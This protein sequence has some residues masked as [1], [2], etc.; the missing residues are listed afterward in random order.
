MT[1]SWPPD[2]LLTLEEWEALPQGRYRCELAEGVLFVVPNP[3]S[4]H[5][6]A[7]M[8]LGYRIDEQLPPQ[9]TAITEL[10]V[11]V[12][13][14]PLTIRVPDVL[15]TRTELYETN[16]RRVPAA[17]VLLAVETLSDGTRRVD[18]I[19]KLAEYA[20][21][22]IPQ[23]WIVDVDSP[24]TV[25]VHVLVNGH[26]ERSGEHTARRS[27]RSPATPSCSTWTR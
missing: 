4:W 21:A 12:S 15:V 10:E 27:S 14:P 17:D 22:G 1:L 11:V 6:K 2:H 26:Y 20:E 19:L 8:R 16:P 24:V 25:E 5:Q 18:R 3:V 7:G 13:A 9:L 23:Y